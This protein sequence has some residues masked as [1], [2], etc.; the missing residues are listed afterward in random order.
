M[1][2]YRQALEI[3]PNERNIYDLA[4]GKGTRRPGRISQTRKGDIADAIAHYEQALESDP[5]FASAHLE[6]GRSPGSTRASSMRPSSISTEH[7]TGSPTGGGRL[8][9]LGHRAG[10][11]R[12]RRTR[13]LQFPQ[14]AESRSQLRLVPT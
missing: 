14:G 9:Q 2:Q 10:S 7:R 11:A 5:G 12:N 6:L 1:A 13:R 8:L 3:G 4:A